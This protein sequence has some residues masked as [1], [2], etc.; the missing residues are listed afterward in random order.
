MAIARAANASRKYRSVDRLRWTFRSR[1]DPICARYASD[2]LSDDGLSRDRRDF[3]F[4][5][6]S[7]GVFRRI[8]IGSASE[9]SCTFEKF[10][11]IEFGT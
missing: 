1:K 7:V 5:R 10:P 8:C 6:P 3:L 9:R 4:N 2:P 11:I